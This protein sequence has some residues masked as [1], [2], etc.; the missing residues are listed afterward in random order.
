MAIDLG[1]QFEK[2]RNS[3]KEFLESGSIISNI[4]FLILVIIGF[5]LLLR[6]GTG[7]LGWLFNP[8]PNVIVSPGMRNASYQLVVPSDPTVHGSVPIMRSKNEWRGI[9][10]TWSC[11]IFIDGNQLDRGKDRFRHVF[12]K[13]NTNIPQSNNQPKGEGKDIAHFGAV[14][15]IVEP[16][17]GP[18]L[19]ISPNNS[20]N[21]AELSL[22]VRMNIF[23]NEADGQP[24]TQLNQACLDAV[25]A[26]KEN[27]QFDASKG[28]TASTLASCRKEFAY[29][30]SSG[31]PGMGSDALSPMIYDDVI[32]PEIPINKWVSVIIRLENNNI[33]DIYING[34]LV[35]RHHLRGVARQNYG[36]TN[37]ALNGG[38][39]GQISELRYFNY[40]IGTAEID[41]I[42]DNGPNLTATGN[43]LNAKPYYLAN[44]WFNDNLDPVYSFSP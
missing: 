31:G 39:G 37:I 23:T 14:D 4:V 25:Q 34:R 1:Y 11:W 36:P 22:L 21:V 29:L 20:P 26:V 28:T 15:G 8:K 35:R 18:G 38:F 24:L 9:E 2:A 10:F 16:L 42:V 5:V 44:R 32:I 33:L 41:W 6:L 7:I 30:N 3:T 12:S 13:G 40:A 19:Y 17:N 43:D 27:G